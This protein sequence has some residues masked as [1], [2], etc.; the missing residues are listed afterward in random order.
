MMRY[1]DPVAMSATVPLSPALKVTGRL[2][3]RKTLCGVY[4]ICRAVAVADAIGMNSS[5]RTMN[6]SLYS[7]FLSAAQFQA[8]LPGGARMFAIV[9]AVAFVCL[10]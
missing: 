5:F 8:S 4:G 7:R 10:S 1:R 3:G 9:G 6:L 2:I